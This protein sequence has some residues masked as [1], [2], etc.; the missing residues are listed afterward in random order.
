[1]KLERRTPLTNGHLHSEVAAIVRV[2]GLGN[3]NRSIY[4]LEGYPKNRITRTTKNVVM[5]YNKI[6]RFTTPKK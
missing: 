1:M 3:L 4:N 2:C 5:F 6:M